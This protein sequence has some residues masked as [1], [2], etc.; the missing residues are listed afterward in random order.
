MPIVAEYAVMV[1]GK[2]DA[3]KRA[4]FD[5]QHCQAYVTWWCVNKEAVAWRGTSIPGV[6]ECPFWAPVPLLAELPWY[7][8]MFGSYVRIKGSRANNGCSMP[9][10]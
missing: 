6:H 10:V 8:R 3:E 2:P 9:D 7:Q 1:E 4:C 5:C